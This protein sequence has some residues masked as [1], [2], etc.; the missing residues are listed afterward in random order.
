MAICEEAWTFIICDGDGCKA[1]TD[2]V[3]GMD[4]V[5][6]AAAVAL[7][8][9]EHPPFDEIEMNHTEWFCPKCAKARGLTEAT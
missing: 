1:R 9:V 5:S 2:S 4:E 7:G 6:A 8:W 3:R